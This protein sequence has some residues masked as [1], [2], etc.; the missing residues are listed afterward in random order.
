[1]RIRD[2]SNEEI[3]DVVKP[4]A[5]HTENSWNSK[6]YHEFC[7]YLAGGSNDSEFTEEEFNRQL[8]ESYDV[9]GCHTIGDLIAIHRNPDNVIVLWKVN[10]EKRK[11]P[12]LLMYEFIERDGQ[13]LIP[14]CSY[15][16]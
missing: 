5:E 9:F 13:I 14:A 16:T 8:K 11:D 12:G 7:R 1:M 4:L 10:F 15:H 2:L 6:D 3:I